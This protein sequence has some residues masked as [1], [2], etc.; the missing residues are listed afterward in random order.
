MK[1][2]ASRHNVSEPTDTDNRVSNEAANCVARNVVGELERVGI[3]AAIVDVPVAAH[4]LPAKI[5]TAARRP[6]GHVSCLG[7][8]R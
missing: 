6:H 3:A 7:F 2:N 4:Q 8:H 5:P 1:A